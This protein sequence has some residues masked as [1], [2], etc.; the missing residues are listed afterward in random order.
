MLTGASDL[1][2]GK[3]YPL[4]KALCHERLPGRGHHGHTGSL[5]PLPILPQICLRGPLF[6]N[7]PDWGLIKIS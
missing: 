1:G 5:G 7:I 4:L 6:D 2:Q 3:E